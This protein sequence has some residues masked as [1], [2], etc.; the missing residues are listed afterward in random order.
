MPLHPAG[1]GQGVH[2]DFGQVCSNGAW[3]NNFAIDPTR[4]AQPGLRPYR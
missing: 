4:V 2:V 1:G 3:Y